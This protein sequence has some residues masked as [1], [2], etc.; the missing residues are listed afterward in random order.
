MSVYFHPPPLLNVVPA[1]H[2]GWERQGTP[3]LLCGGDT[4]NDTPSA[5]RLPGHRRAFGD[6][7]KWFQGF[8]NWEDKDP[9]GGRLGLIRAWSGEQDPLKNPGGSGGGLS[10]LLL[11]WQQL[12]M[13]GRASSWAATPCFGWVSHCSRL[14]DG[15]TCEGKGP[16]KPPVVEKTNLHMST[17]RV[18]QRGGCHRR[19]FAQA[20]LRFGFFFPWSCW[21]PFGILKATSWCYTY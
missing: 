5:H 6:A 8:G 17:E 19:G 10:V 4:K 3:R 12:P 15:W 1:P 13:M 16:E 20:S 9:G 18:L 21:S 14:G 2:L 7:P 11:G